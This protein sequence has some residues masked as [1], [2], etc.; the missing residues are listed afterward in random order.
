MLHTLLIALSLH[1][2]VTP[3]PA[4]DSI[5]SDLEIRQTVLRNAG[6]VRRCYEF[7]GLR[8][9]PSLAGSV[10]IALTVLP[11][12]AVD[13]VEVAEV[14]LRGEGTREV[15]RCITT[16]A[17]NWRFERGPYATETI[18]LPFRL[19]PDMRSPITKV[20]GT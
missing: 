11:T 13:S 2:P 20:S 5:R 15:T 1:V 4:T 10:E 12:G 18:L 19:R 9:D 7:E 8:R 16:V 14:A 6:D 3:M 17:R